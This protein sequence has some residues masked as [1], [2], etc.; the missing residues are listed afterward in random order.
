MSPDM[1][2][3]IGTWGPIL[4]MVAVFYFLLYRPQKNEQKRR[5]AMLDS[6]KTGD[7]VVTIGG[8]YG[9]IT[10]LDEKSVRLKIANQVE[11]K[12][13]RSAVASVTESEA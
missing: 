7:E 5:Q 8:I 13:A 4:V 6:L 11:I 10:A 2:A 3:A 9:V 1:L 12:A